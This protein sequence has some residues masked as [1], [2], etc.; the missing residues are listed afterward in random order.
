MPTFDPDEQY[1]PNKPN[2]LGEYQWYR[3]QVKEERRARLLEEKQRRAA[4]ESSEGS[5]YYTDSEEE[6]APRRDGEAIAPI[7]GLHH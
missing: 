1:D 3:K 2:D 5:S 4:G 7:Q 6:A